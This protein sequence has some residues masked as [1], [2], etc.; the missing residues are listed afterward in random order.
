MQNVIGKIKI[1]TV[2]VMDPTL[3]PKSAK[4]EEEEFT[5]AKILYFHPTATDIHEKRKQVGISEGIVSFFLPFTNNEEPI[6]CISTLNFT[7]VMKQ[8]ETDIWLNMVITHPETLYGPRQ[9]AKE[10][11]ETIANTKFRA[12]LFREED[13]KIFYKLLDVYYRYFSLFHGTFRDLHQ[14]HEDTFE[15]VMDDF[16]KNFEYHF[17]SKEFEKNFFWNLSL[18]GL[19]YCPIEKK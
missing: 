10:E 18:Q 13:S 19:F 3:K 16:T 5:D 14:K 1:G 2:F 15:Q 12:N 9:T 11:M 6:Q 17:F 8:V 4:P 7:H